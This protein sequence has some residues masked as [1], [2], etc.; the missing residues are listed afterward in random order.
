M[1]KA[2]LIG[3]LGRDPEIRTFPNG[4]KIVNVSL[5]TTEMWKDR[6][7][8][9]IKEIA[10]WHKLV[11]R[12]RLAEIVHQYA[13]KGTKMFVEGKSRARKYQKD[14]RDVEVVEVIVDDME[15]LGTPA[16]ASQR[17]QPSPQQSQHPADTGWCDEGDGVGPIF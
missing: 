17:Q 9:E 6:E 2:M 7:T 13:K 12:N 10:D 11:F 15:L 5:C 3:N 8:G 16:H 4:N 14:G 1:N